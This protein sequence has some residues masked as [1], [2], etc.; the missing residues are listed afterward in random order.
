M[1]LDRNNPGNRFNPQDPEA[2]EQVQAD[3]RVRV[4]L[5]VPGQVLD[6]AL[7]PE[8]IQNRTW[9]AVHPADLGQ[10]LLN[11]IRNGQVSPAIVTQVWKRQPWRMLDV[12]DSVLDRSTPM[13]A[14]LLEWRTIAQTNP[15][16]EPNFKAL[17][18]D[19]VQ[20]MEALR[21]GLEAF[22]NTQQ[23]SRQHLEGLM[24]RRSSN[25]IDGVWRDYRRSINF[26][27]DPALSAGL[28]VGGV[29]VGMWLIRG[30]SRMARWARFG[31]GFT[32]FAAFLRKTYGITI[33]ED[34]IA[35]PLEQWGAPQMANAVRVFRDTLRAPFMGTEQRGS[36]VALIEHR[37]NVNG[38]DERTMLAGILRM[39]PGR[40]VTAYNAAKRASLGTAGATQ[41]PEEVRELI[42][43][44]QRNHQI[45]DHLSG[46]NDNEK[47]RVFLRVA[48]KYLAALGEGRDP[49]RG[50]AFLE[51]NFVSG[52]AYQVM[53]ARANARRLRDGTLRADAQAITDVEGLQTASDA[54]AS[55]VSDV[56]MLD[57]YLATAGDDFWR[58]L[59]GFQSVEARR[60]R[61]LRDALL[62]TAR[63]GRDV[64]VSAATTV[65]DFVLNDVPRFFTDEVWP[66]AQSLAEAAWPRL[67]DFGQWVDTQ[68]YQFRKNTE[69][70]RLLE[71]LAGG[72]VDAGSEVISVSGREMKK[73]A[74][75]VSWKR[76]GNRI[77][78]TD[79][80]DWQTR[81]LSQ[82]TAQAGA[83]T[84]RMNLTQPADALV[85]R[86]LHDL[87]IVQVQNRSALDGTPTEVVVSN[88]EMRKFTEWLTLLSDV[89]ST[90]GRPTLTFPPA[91]TPA[92]LPTPSAAPTTTPLNVPLLVG[93]LQTRI[94]TLGFPSVMFRAHPSL[95]GTIEYV[96]AALT[97]TPPA[98]T[99]ANRVIAQSVATDLQGKTALQ[100][101]NAYTAWLTRPAARLNERDPLTYVP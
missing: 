57:V 3:V 24:G 45:A 100:I 70:G 19:L 32:I 95:P 41:L 15:A 29:M 35:R 89:I 98:P 91:G 47:L 42:R 22:L 87:G 44:F 72:A 97:F 14:R 67:K 40:F 61:E 2:V 1:T 69:I 92:P 71:T 101:H 23:A 43:E 90:V 37:L 11:A 33:T 78:T 62:S 30:R 66:R 60:A 12:F 74:V 83:P 31:A 68:Q 50:L 56:N 5:N 36:A 75:W 55:P 21:Q 13:Y 7:R 94:N 51:G 28:L 76:L 88:A 52:R 6:S 8:T 82:A 25:W 79:F 63:Q 18:V 27:R 4:P 34:L 80:N 46:L 53:I 86:S 81:M 10:I 16:F 96:E 99:D 58:G 59:E 17:N 38:N 73:L 26:Q 39:S 9:E 64:V 93:D 77:G 54:A 84:I 20:R 65:R 48:D 85:W 49:Q